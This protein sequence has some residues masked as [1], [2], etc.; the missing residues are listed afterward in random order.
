MTKQSE[1][2]NPSILF[3]HTSNADV[4]AP[5]TFHSRLLFDGDGTPKYKNSLGAVSSFGG[6]ITNVDDVVT[7]ADK[8]SFASNFVVT[9]QGSGDALVNAY[10]PSSGGGGGTTA[11][12]ATRTAGSVAMNSTA[13]ADFD[14]GIDLTIAAVAGDK[15]IV[16]LSGQH[17]S[18]AITAYLD[19]ATI[20]SAAPVNYV[21]VAGGATDQ[22]V[23]AWLCPPVGFA[24]IGGTVLYTVQAGDISGGNVVLR[25]RYRTSSAANKTLAATATAPLKWYVMNIGQ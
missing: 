18:E 25:L 19:A 16:G 8:I 11:T 14:T 17:G 12:S 7:G 24:G 2:H 15:L 21:G 5:A 1:N 22:G 23:L 13:W 10:F 9:D 20:V 6:G 3:A 4:A